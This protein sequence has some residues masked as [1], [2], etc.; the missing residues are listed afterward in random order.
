[1]IDPT[2]LLQETTAWISYQTSIYIGSFGG[3]GVGT[4]GGILGALAGVLAPKGQARGFVIGSF[5]TIGVLGLLS[6]L[7]AL[8]A[9]VMGQPTFVWSPFGLLGLVASSVCLPLTVVMKKRYEEAEARQLEAHS[10]RQS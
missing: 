10:L 8:V 5:L 9:L 3:A 2:P 7:F 1:M 6:L 4:L